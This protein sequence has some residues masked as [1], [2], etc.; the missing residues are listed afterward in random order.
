MFGVFIVYETIGTAAKSSLGPTA[1]SEITIDQATDSNGRFVPSFM[2]DSTPLHSLVLRPIN[3]VGEYEFY[4]TAKQYFSNGSASKIVVTEPHMHEG[5]LVTEFALPISIDGKFAGVVGVSRPLVFA[6]EAIKQ[7]AI[8]SGLNVYL[9]T[10]EDNFVTAYAG[11]TTATEQTRATFESIS[12]KP[13][14][15]TPWATSLRTL[16]AQSGKNVLGTA[17]NPLNNAETIHAMTRVALNDW[18]VVVEIPRARLI[19]EIWSDLWL[20]L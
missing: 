16:L 4:K 14:D 18:K 17:V 5:E 7:L 12:G 1:A 3:N 2:R 20:D 19:H 10:D 15:K 9:L 11:D 6:S 8:E 13:L